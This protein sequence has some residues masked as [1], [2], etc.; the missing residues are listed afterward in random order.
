MDADK[1][2]QATHAEA[3]RALLL[4]CLLP[5]IFALSFGLRKLPQWPR[6]ITWLA[7]SLAVWG[8]V[9]GNV[10]YPL[11]SFG[12]ATRIFFITALLP[13]LWSFTRSR[14][15]KS[16]Q[17]YWLPL[18]IAIAVLVTA[19]SH[20]VTFLEPLMLVVLVWAATGSQSGLKRWLLVLV[21]ALLAYA[22]TFAGWTH[23]VGGQHA[24]LPKHLDVLWG[25]AAGGIYGAWV[26]G[27]KGAYSRV[28]TG[29]LFAFGYLASQLLPLALRPFWPVVVV[30]CVL[31]SKTWTTPTL[32]RSD[33]L[34]L[35]CAA[36]CSVQMGPI[37]WSVALLLGTCT[38]K[39]LAAPSLRQTLGADLAMVL[40]GA[41]L[42]SL[43]YLWVVCEGN[44]LIFSDV[45][46]LSGLLGGAVPMYLPLV[47]TL[48]SLYY[49]APL[50]LA[51]GVW[52]R[53]QPDILL[54]RGVARATTTMLGLRLLFHF[55]GFTW[56]TMAWGSW[57]KQLIEVLLLLT[58]LHVIELSLVILGKPAPEPAPVLVPGRVPLL[59]VSP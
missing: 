57:E 25:M 9:F 13:C 37:E 12:D 58:W 7:A 52:F 2:I 45:R 54:Y 5:T 35:G 8:W 18:Y 31:L 48:T 1:V 51:L 24:G 49:A 32:R 3:P 28:T 53:T 20:W 15:S 50:L 56:G 4:L 38:G 47:V 29:L 17:R 44:Q 40:R 27:E 26:H 55:V 6:L 43:G 19:D 41:S 39:A 33:A 36:L 46:V 22:L 34:L 30:A 10:V 59:R 42:L 11:C 14:R 23:L 21:A 16:H